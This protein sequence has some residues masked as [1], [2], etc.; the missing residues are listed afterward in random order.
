M[1]VAMTGSRPFTL[2]EPTIEDVAQRLAEIYAPVAFSRHPMFSWL[3]IMND[4]TILGEELRRERR[5]EAVERASAVLVR[6]LEFIGYYVSVHPTGQGGMSDMV[7]HALRQ[8]S[9]KDYIPNGLVE[10]LTRWILVKYPFACSKCGEAQCQCLLAPWILENRREEPD[11]YFTRFQSRAEGAR[12]QLKNKHL[13]QF[14]LK[15]LIDHFGAIYRANYYHQDPWKIGMHLSEEMGEATIELGRIELRWR[16]EEGGFDIKPEVES[17]LRIAA[18]RIGEQIGKIDEGKERENHRA[19]LQPKLDE[20]KS[21]LKKDPWRLYG[22]LVAD[23]FKEEVADVLSWLA[24]IVVKLDPHLDEFK[25]FP[26]RFVH[27]GI[28][29]VRSLGCPWCHAVDRCSNS[30]L[31]VHGVSSEITE[32]VLK[33]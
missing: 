16:A 29:G 18:A 6:L 26:D 32:S 9:Y 8:P 10:G 25:K 24:A 33:F 23:K 7:A 17:I 13:Q 20:I 5:K 12:A 19:R 4:V 22:D 14:T 31:V 3:L 21:R 28:G 27:T 1:E 11:Q 2:E 30:C 15:S